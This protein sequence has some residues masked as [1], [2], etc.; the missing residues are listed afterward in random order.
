MMRIMGDLPGGTVTFLLTDIE[1]STRLWDEHAAEAGPILAR[2]DALI[3][4][5]V[6]NHDGDTVRPRGEGDSRFC[7]FARATDAVAAA[8]ALQRAFV[9]EEWAVPLKVRMAIHTGEAEL[10][11]G[12]YYG[13]APN[14]CARLRALAAGNQTLVSR[15]TRDLVADVLPKGAILRDLGA[16]RLQDLARPEQVFELVRDDVSG[17]EA[18]GAV[19]PSARQGELP[20]IVPSSML[21][22]DHPMWRE[23]LRQVLE[24]TGVARVVAE[25]GDGVEAIA[26]AQRT[27]PDIIIMDVD[28]PSLDGVEVTRRIVNI[29]P[30][31]RI[32]MLSSSSARASVVEAI[33]AGASGYLVKTAGSSEIADAVVRIQRGDLVFPSTIAGIVLEEIRAAA[34]ATGRHSVIPPAPSPTRSAA[35]MKTGDFWTLRFQDRES[36]VKDARGMTYI[37]ALLRAPREGLHVLELTSAGVAA[38]KRRAAKEDAL[39]VGSDDDPVLDRKAIAAYRQRIL[40]LQQEIDQA[41]SWDDA[42]RSSVLTTEMQE[43]EQA[44]LSGLGLGGRARNAPSAAGRA[45]VSV[46]NAITAALKTIRRHDERLWQHLTRS[47]RTGTFCVY[48]PEDRPDWSL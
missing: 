14:R 1:G 22:D 24:A 35:F 41:D 36:H 2:H 28:L 33:Q 32:L 25:A 38:V 20:E 30:E 15:R 23:T 19:G 46:R 18:R 16:R 13:G 4:Q 7:V 21:V 47:I 29:L 26:E 11:G 8:L 9:N 44:L 17:A 5:V 10:R 34:G 43:L 31:V 3:E 45:R 12:D 6:A 48:D 27:R 40:D 39:G 37:A 42:D